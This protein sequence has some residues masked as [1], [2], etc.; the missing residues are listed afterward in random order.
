MRVARCLTLLRSY[1]EDITLLTQTKEDMEHLLTLQE[2]LLWSY[3]QQR[4][5]LDDDREPSR[6]IKN[7]GGCEDQIR[8]RCNVTRS[9][10]DRLK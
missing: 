3:T 2:T 8:R 9:A 5:D 1:Y 4:K 10:I 7:T 6:T